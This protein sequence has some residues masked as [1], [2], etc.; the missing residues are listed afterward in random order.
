MIQ[1]RV[2]LTPQ[3][4]RLFNFIKAKYRLKDR[5]EAVN[6]FVELCADDWLNSFPRSMKE[7]DAQIEE[8]KKTH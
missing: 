6:K 2:K 3:T 8:H 1:S 4:V 5:S 7:W